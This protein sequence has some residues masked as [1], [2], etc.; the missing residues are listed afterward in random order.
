M[1]GKIYDRTELDRALPLIRSIVSEITEAYDRLRDRLVDLGVAHPHM[2]QGVAER[3]LPWDV[4]DIVDEIRSCI[5]E[6]AELGIFLRDPEDGLVE[7]YGEQEGDIVYF[8]WK[9]GEESIGY[10]HGL[11]NGSTDRVPVAAQA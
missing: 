3:D 8:S 9:P 4:R 11:F 7:A 2:R 5:D 6:L 1:R 10:W